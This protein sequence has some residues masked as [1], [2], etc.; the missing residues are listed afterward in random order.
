MIIKLLKS[1]LYAIIVLLTTI[2]C[3]G[4][5]ATEDSPKTITPPSAALLVSPA[6]DESCNQGNSISDT[7]STVSF[8]WNTSNDTDKYTIQVKNLENDQIQEKTTTENNSSFDLN[9]GTS[10]EWHV[11][12]LSNEIDETETSEK[13]TFFNAASGVEN[14][15]PYAAVVIFP[16]NDA[17]IDTTTVSLEWQGQ[18]LDNDI[19]SYTIYLDT[20]DTPNLINS[21]TSEMHTSE[22]T[23]NANTTYY[24]KVHTKDTAGNISISSIF[25][26][27]TGS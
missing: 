17:T 10:Y 4:D 24:W 11:I 7:K 27:T 16:T 3:G 20:D 12:S 14:H 19:E 2:N 8:Q 21:T 22:I 26:F 25:K 13:W 6:K 23:L 5:E 18:D 1:I 9:K 15:V